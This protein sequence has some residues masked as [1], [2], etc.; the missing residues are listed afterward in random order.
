M[1]G[2]FKNNQENQKE[3]IDVYCLR[4][5]KKTFFKQE[6]EYITYDTSRGQKFCL[7]GISECDHVV[8]KIVKKREEVQ[9]Q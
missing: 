3:K 9:N 4:C 5:K 2:I 7:R 1:L 6:P 8:S